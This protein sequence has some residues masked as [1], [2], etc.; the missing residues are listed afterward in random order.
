MKH[1]K[2]S[3]IILNWNGKHLLKDCLDSVFNQTYPNYEVILVD[4]GSTD[5]SVELVK[6]EYPKAKLIKNDKNY[7]FA[8]GNNIGIR[9]ALKDPEV[10]NIVLLNN[11]TKAD[12]NWLNELAD[13]QADI[14]QSKILT[15]DGQ[16][17]STGLLYSR[18]GLAFDWKSSRHDEEPFGA[19][20][21]AASFKREVLEDTKLNEDFFDGDFFCYS[22]DADLSFRSRLRGWV[23]KYVP[24]SVVYHKGS[25]TAGGE[26]KFSIYYGHR[27]NVWVLIKNMPL[28]L[29]IKYFWKIFLAQIGSV[30][31]YVVRGNGTTIIKAKFDAIKQIPKMLEKRKLI[32][33]KRTIPI[34]KLDKLLVDKWVPENFTI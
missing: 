10:E 23:I 6:K 22:E 4:N 8:E 30:L 20:G 12:K 31:F 33:E 17:S 32:Q 28:Q 14:A 25:A 3:I 11:D 16:I 21:V 19:S 18:N 13:A 34:E 5:G 9:F 27:N 29:L 2:V 15:P 26:S 7:G 24:K 1:P